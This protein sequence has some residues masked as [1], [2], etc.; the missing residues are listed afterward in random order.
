LLAVLGP[1][2]A[3]ALGPLAALLPGV[4]AYAAASSLSAFFT[5]HLGRPQWAAKIAGL[6]LALN[7]AGALWAVPRFGMLGAAW[8]T[9]VSYGIAITVAAAWFLRETGLPWRALVRR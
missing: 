7:T 9:S 1:A 6:S 8:S 2:Y 5:N 3:P 4:A